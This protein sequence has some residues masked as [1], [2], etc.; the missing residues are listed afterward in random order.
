M[1]LVAG[2]HSAVGFRLAEDDYQPESMSSPTEIMFVAS[3]TSMWSSSPYKSAKRRFVFATSLACR[4]ATS[5]RRRRNAI[6]RW[7]TGPSDDPPP[8]SV[9]EQP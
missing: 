9:R 2:M 4:R 1:R 5:A 6:L 7:R 8:P 3:A